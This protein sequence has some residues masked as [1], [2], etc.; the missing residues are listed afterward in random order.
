MDQKRKLPKSSATPNLIAAL[1]LLFAA[2]LIMAIVLIS[3]AHTNFRD[4]ISK[5]MLDIGNTAADLL[6]ADFMERMTLS[7]IGSEDYEKALR[8]LRIFEENIDLSYIYAVRELG[9]GSFVFTI[10]PDPNDPAPFGYPLDWDQELSVA[11]GGTPAV[12]KVPHTDRWG[13]FYTAYTPILN[14]D[15]NVVGIIGVD[16][17]ASLYSSQLAQDV[18]LIIAITIIMMVIGVIMSVLIVRRKR[19]QYAVIDREMTALQDG[20]E[21]LNESMM[22]SS[23]L[24]LHESPKSAEN[25]L[26]KTLA[27]GSVYNDSLQRSRVDAVTD[28]STRM[29]RMQEALKHYISYLDSQT[30]VDS[31][32]GVCNKAAYKRS[33]EQI[34]SQIRE[35]KAAFAVGFFDINEM[36][37]VNSNFGFE[38][39]DAMLYATAS[40]LTQVFQQKNVY[41]VASDEFIVIMHGKT[42][43]DMDAYFRS[44][45]EGIDRFNAEQKYPVKLAV[46]RG[47]AVYH[48]DMGENYR[49]V[50]LRAEEN[51]KRD[52]SAYYSAKLKE[53]T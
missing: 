33:L 17:D 46:A 53:N 1:I 12:E 22:T 11:A 23:V 9:D 18:A 38:V 4:Q 26:L 36:R 2:N 16:Y 35:E 25:D 32:T 28:I 45:G 5:R 6:D 48:T 42:L 8:T 50:F 52:K 3:R 29:Q 13:T 49:Q 10:D 19:Q 24:R 43:T 34:E 15:R 37:Y 40:I 14:K 31:M 27:S 30:Y 44:F 41:R 21:R 7:D 47:S 51:E 39:G 20:F